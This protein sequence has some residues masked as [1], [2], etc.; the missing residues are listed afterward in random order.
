VPKTRNQFIM[1]NTAPRSSSVRP[2]IS[3][4][5]WSRITA[6]CK[7]GRGRCE[8]S[9]RLTPRSPPSPALHSCTCCAKGSLQEAVRRAAVRPNSSTLWLRNPHTDKGH[10]PFHA[11][12]SKFCDRA[13]AVTAH[14]H[15][16]EAISA[17]GA[18]R[19]AGDGRRRARAG[20]DTSGV[21]RH[22][23]VLQQCRGGVR[24]SHRYPGP[25]G[26]H[27]YA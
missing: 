9:K 23:Y 7:E 20:V 13:C 2:S 25:R 3:I 16:G 18:V 8:R 12:L 1:R 27:R 11:P 22:G 5:S 17:E 6:A 19:D 15:H 4:I 21:Q 14:A 24:V 26:A 10:L